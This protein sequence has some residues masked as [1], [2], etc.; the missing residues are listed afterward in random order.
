MLGSVWGFL[1]FVLVVMGLAGGYPV[2]AAVGG[3][4]LLVAGGAWVWSRLSLERLGL[5][6][7]ALREPGLRG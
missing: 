6:A 4:G 5:R 1:F 7:V 3:M 2:L